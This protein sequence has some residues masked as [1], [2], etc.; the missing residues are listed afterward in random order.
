[1]TSTV[2]GNPKNN[3][4]SSFPPSVPPSFIR[5]FPV[6]PEHLNRNKH[7]EHQHNNISTFLEK[8]DPDTDWQA[9]FHR[10]HV[11][12]DKHFVSSGY[13]LRP[14][15]IIIHDPR[16]EIPEPLVNPHYTVLYEDDYLVAI[17]K[18]APLPIH[19]TGTY[20]H[21]SL[22]K[23]LAQAGIFWYPIHRLDSETSGVLLLTKDPSQVGRMSDALKAGS[24]TYLIMV[25]G[26]TPR[27]FH[28]K[29][30]LGPKEG[31]AVFKRQGY[32]PEGKNS[33]S[34]FRRIKVFHRKDQTPYTLTLLYARL[35]TGRNHQLRAHLSEKGYAVVGDKIYGKDE[36]YFIHHLEKGLTGM[37]KELL[38]ELEISRQFLHC[39]RVSL[40][41]PYTKKTLHIRAPFH[42]GEGISNFLEK[43]KTNMA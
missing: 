27:H 35:H 1:M 33:H 28:V 24:K 2:F 34:E 40:V 23:I 30:P 26:E 8:Q 13:S 19:P 38:Q 5:R 18:P 16:R 15:T 36:K 21:H 3:H 17:N 10:G 32:H 6:L 25:Y 41:H 29:I 22:T 20:F 39:R 4:E 43:L 7:N 11:R 9:E 37:S 42:R 31:S 14:H 12:V